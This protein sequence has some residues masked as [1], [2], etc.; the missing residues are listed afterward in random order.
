MIHNNIPL[1]IEA[2]K[3]KASLEFLSQ[4]V[5]KTDRDTT[6]I[7]DQ[8][9]KINRLSRIE[10]R[11]PYNKPFTLAEIQHVIYYIPK[12][13]PGSDMTFHQF[14]SNL[15]DEWISCL[16]DLINQACDSGCFP[17]IWKQPLQ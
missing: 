16:L 17:K 3:S 1:L 13:A 8:N 2:Q 11:E 9:S 7:I 15:K 4:T 10:L 5:G 6:R 14:I 12:T